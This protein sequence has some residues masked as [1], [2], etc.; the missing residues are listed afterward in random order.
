MAI[1]KGDVKKFVKERFNVMME[2]AAAEKMAEMLES[3]AA[4]IA[5]Y[6]VE[7]AKKGSKAVCA[8]DI[9]AYKLEHGN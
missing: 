9:D 4:E 1:S 5:K 3:K 8:E 7:H 6:A 2:D